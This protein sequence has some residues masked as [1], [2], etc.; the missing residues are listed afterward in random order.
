[1]NDDSILLASRYVD[2]DMDTPEKQDF[3]L[4]MQSDAELRAYV[5]QYKQA[6]DA[7]KIR[8]APNAGLDNLKQTLSGLNQQYFKEEAKVVSMRPKYIKWLSAVAAVLFIGLMVWQPWQKSLY[9]Q[10]STAT[11]M[12]VAERG[13]SQETDLDR[14]AAFYNKKEF[15][16]A[17]K[18]L[19][20]EYAAHPE[21][22][23]V[24]YYYAITLIEDK[25]EP[26]ARFILEKLY[27]GE[28]AFKYNAAY[29]IALSYIKQKDKENCKKWL[30]LIPNGNSNSTKATELL[31]KL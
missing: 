24:A 7:L 11:S 14:A 31:A 19:E 12:S 25:Q 26:R 8:F 27:K 5:D 15:V 9:E 13:A 21:N 1:M 22:S 18:L 28:S 16:N 20:K 30:K 23:L 17:E 6:N 2:G 10:Y 3:E 29:Y 4:L